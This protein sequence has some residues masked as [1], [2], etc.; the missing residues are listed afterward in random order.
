MGEQKR[1][2]ALAG[3][4]KGKKKKWARVS[5]REKKDNTPIFIG[6]ESY[7]KVLDKV[8]KMKCISLSKVSD[9]HHITASL[10]KRVIR[11]LQQGEIEKI[12]DTGSVLLYKKMPK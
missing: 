6:R 9:A 10:A 12:F 4:K 2:A 3:S 8:P 11:Q 7:K 1:A 5:R